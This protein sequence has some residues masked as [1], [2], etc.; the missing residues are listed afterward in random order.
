MVDFGGFCLDSGDGGLCL[1]AQPKSVRNSIERMTANG[2][3]GALR[4]F[5]ELAMQ[6][7]RFCTHPSDILTQGL[8]KVKRSDA[9]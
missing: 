1:S 6:S 2:V 9:T 4:V 5:L 7:K 3:G 8:L